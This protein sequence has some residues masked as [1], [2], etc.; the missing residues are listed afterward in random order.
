MEPP[1]DPV[2]DSSRL[3]EPAWRWTNVILGVLF[4][5]FIGALLLATRAL[6]ATDPAQLPPGDFL[7]ST[8][9]D[10]ATRGSVEAIYRETGGALLWTTE[11]RRLNLLQAIA[12]LDS[13]GMDVGALGLPE[14][15]TPQA[16][17]THDVLFTAALVRA[18]VHLSGTNTRQSTGDQGGLSPRS[19]PAPADIVRAVRDADI[20]GY[21][22]A[23]RPRDPEY[24]LLRRAYTRYR[25]AARLEVEQP[26]DPSLGEIVLD[27]PD[28]RIPI[29]ERRL[30]LLSELDEVPMPS[31]LPAAVMAFQARH[32]LSVDGRVGQA[33]LAALNLP[34]AARARQIATNLKVWRGLPRQWP[35][36]Y[37]R[38][39]A[40]AALLELVENGA[41]AHRA[42]VIVGD[43]GHPTPL[44]AAEINA[45]TFNPDWTV[46]RSISVR[47]I[48][49]K[50]RRNPDYLQ[51]NSMT[52]IG[53]EDDPFGLQ[54]DWK[55][56]SANNFPFQLRQA[57]GP[58]NPL[59]VVKFEM[60]NAQSVFLHDTPNRG[61]FAKASRALSHGCVRVEDAH[62]FAV[63]LIGSPQVW[64]D[65]SLAH[66]DAEG[67]TITV[68][69]GRTVPVYLLYFTVFVAD[70]TLNFRSDV[71]G[72]NKAEEAGSRAPL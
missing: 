53:R 3:R 47:E 49:P 54:L 48:L 11:A 5:L 20:V 29:L 58:K 42:R 14:T 64:L 46:P 40:A 69:L 72:R 38:V 43:P 68:P 67:K 1:V 32:G 31:D 50:L 25:E 35:A 8:L 22:R 17:A 18:A 7:A 61:T 60:P 19:P 36:A 6:P 59:G 30:R 4:M 12:S 39:N 55:A 37:V 27:S 23:L 52:I 63:R 24:Q 51:Q 13:D 15:D 16:G 28:V 71:Y 33:T 70:G 65:G 21:F 45:V 41:T 44:L 56:Y 9:L 10:D 2:S 34:L 66:A 62:G 57:A 26:L